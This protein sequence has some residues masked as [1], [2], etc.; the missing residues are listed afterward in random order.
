MF[1]DPQFAIDENAEEYKVLHPHADKRKD[2]GRVQELL[3][4]HFEVSVNT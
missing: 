2:K 3:E 1:E 4:E